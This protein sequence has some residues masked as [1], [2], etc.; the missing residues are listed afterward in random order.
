VLFLREVYPDPDRCIHERPAASATQVLLSLTEQ[1]I[2]MAA[3]LGQARVSYYF[4][5]DEADLTLAC[6]LP[7][8]LK[9]AR[10]AAG[11]EGESGIRHHGVLLRKAV[12]QLVAQLGDQYLS[13]RQV[14]P[15]KVLEELQRDH[16]LQCG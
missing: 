4:Q 14:P 13:L 7:Y 5:N 3:R 6:A 11:A 12:E 15:E 16:R 9:L 2:S 1:V 8:A 10:A